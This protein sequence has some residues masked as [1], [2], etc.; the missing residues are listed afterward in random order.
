MS[1]FGW[2][3][4][5]L[6][7]LLAGGAVS[8][9][10]AASVGAGARAGAAA[11][12]AAGAGEVRVPLQTYTELVEASESEPRPP[13]VG[14]ALGSSQVVVEVKE[15]DD[16]VTAEVRVR[17]TV[18]TFTDDW[19]AVPILPS[20][21]ALTRVTLD[22]RPAQ[23]VQGPDGLS[24]SVNKAQTVAMELVYG[25]DARRS[26]TGYVLPVPVP[27]AAATRLMLRMPGT[28]LDLAVVPSADLTINEPGGKLTEL[29]ASVPATGAILVSWRAGSKRPYVLSRA[30]YQ[31]ELR[32]DALVWQALFEVEAFSGELLT[33]PL[34]PSDIT[35]GELLVDGE[36]ATVVSEDGRFAA[37]VKGRG[38]HRVEVRF[39]TSVVENKGPPQV[40]V[41]I[42]PV[43]ISKFELSL[44]G[45]K[46]VKVSPGGNVVSHESDDG[47]RAQ[48]LVPMGEQLLFSWTDAVPQDLKARVRANAS[49]YQ[50]VH[51]DEGVLHVQGLVAYEITHGEANTLA[52]SLPAAVQ[53]NRI[54]A[55]GGGV[56]DWAV[57]DAAGGRKKVS[58]FLDRAVKGDFQLQLSYEL[59]LGAGQ[60]GDPAAG[61]A[62]TVPLLRA[63]DVHRQRGMVALLSGPDL[64]L[65][66]TD[67]TLVSRVGENQLPAAFRNRIAMTIG[68]TYKYIDPNAR[69]RVEAV[70]PERKQGL[71]DALVDT[72]IS[73]GEVTLKGAA[74]IQVDV[75]SGSIMEL[76]LRL[77]PNLNV[78]GVTGPSLRTYH[79]QQDRTDPTIALEFTRE[80]DGQ[81]R[82]EVSYER[83]MVDT[84]QQTP[85]PVLSVAEAEVEH[86]RIAVEALTAVEIRP[87]ATEQLSSVDVNELPRQLVLKTTNPILLAYKYVKAQGPFRLTLDITRHKEIDVQAAAIE[88]A[89]YRTLYTPDGLAVTTARFTVRNSRQQ[90]LRLELP[91]HS[92]VWAAFVDG[93]AEKPAYAADEG[94]TDAGGESGAVLLKMINSVDGFPVEIVYAT[95][96]AEM[97]FRGRIDSRLPRPDMVA[98]RTRWDVY[99]PAR[100]EY[101]RPESS[102]NLIVGGL[103][104]NPRR[105]VGPGGELAG[106]TAGDAVAGPASKAL[107]IQV[108][109]EGV[110]YAFEKLYANQSDRDAS[111]S[112]GYIA[113][114]G[115]R[116]GLWASLLGVLLLAVG[117]AR[118]IGVRV[119]LSRLFALVLMVIGGLLYAA[120]VGL[121]GADPQPGAA[122][123]LVLLGVGLSYLLLR[124]LLAWRRRRR[125]DDD[126][127]ADAE[128]V[129]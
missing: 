103:L 32:D 22:G 48:V 2:L 116:V 28:G 83:I 67:E 19:T 89:L 38:K 8:A 93:R 98:T 15:E 112:V 113:A 27:T 47:T 79:V 68:H 115:A 13:P 122:M 102:M 1:R 10:Q 40:L 82:I 29:V 119:G 120:T 36:Q 106:R 35:L 60:A 65:R 114:S 87:G 85:V 24:W 125:D 108:P 43:P 118:L 42:P 6:V 61:Q 110:L 52:L 78:L 76:D 74:T 20:G 7:G 96:A 50:A 94:A 80:M 3:L 57:E 128:A 129:E 25:I 45:R 51:A 26:E 17:L 75:K 71:F 39:Q 31:G 46:E 92:E 66:P 121:F 124:G 73:V 34:M 41:R 95:R 64:A 5:S 49:V 126:E 4:L 58:V 55:P 11:G 104:T 77:P 111:F 100:F 105:A 16:R 56:S 90:F 97:G 37:L 109:A 63:L 107:R 54:T 69:L 86:G 9:E 91:Q 72:L 70:A 62:V 23:L 99:L 30:S 18:E 88:Q 14:Y 44:P 21:T 117:V 123:A 53:V 127:E 84:E 33:V 12:A 101:L 59:L 81:F